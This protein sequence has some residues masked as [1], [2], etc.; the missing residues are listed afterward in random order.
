MVEH[1]PS[2]LPLVTH[3]LCCPPLLSQPSRFARNL[4]H[5]PLSASTA[6]F[7]PRGHVSWKIQY[8]LEFQFPVTPF[9][10]SSPAEAEAPGSINRPDFLIR[11]KS[12]SIAETISDIFSSMPSRFRRQVSSSQSPSPSLPPYFPSHSLSNMISKITLKDIQDAKQCGGGGFGTVRIYEHPTK[13][14]VALK[15]LALSRG[16]GDDDIRRV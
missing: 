2:C 3:I 12:G 5:T 7:R 8:P 10:M 15:Q 13:G 14:K 4:P 11:A 16:Q 1:P 9:P 6:S